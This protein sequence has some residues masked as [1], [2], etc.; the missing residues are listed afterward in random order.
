VRHQRGV[1]VLWLGAGGFAPHE[2]VQ[3][4]QGT[5]AGGAPLRLLQ[6]DAAGNLPLVRVLTARGTP[7]TRLAYMLVGRRT[8]A[9]ATA[10]YAPPAT[11]I[12]G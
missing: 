12:G 10:L 5:R 1:T 4:Y 11:R 6:A 3:R 2:T 7:K 9:R 8:G